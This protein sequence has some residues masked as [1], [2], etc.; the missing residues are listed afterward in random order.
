MVRGDYT[1]AFGEDPVGAGPGVAAG[2][3]EHPAAA[4]VAVCQSWS[5]CPAPVPQWA[6]PTFTGHKDE[7]QRRLRK[8]TCIKKIILQKYYNKFNF[9]RCL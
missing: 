4:G 2:R 5:G 7:I 6:W 8:I 3:A 9:D 1:H